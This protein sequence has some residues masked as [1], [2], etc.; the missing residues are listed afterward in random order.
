MKQNVSGI[1]MGRIGLLMGRESISEDR[2]SEKREESER[3]RE[4]KPEL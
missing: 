1:E 4:R 2:W 3:E